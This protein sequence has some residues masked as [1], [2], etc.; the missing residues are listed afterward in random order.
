[1][2]GWWA[3]KIRRTAGY[4]RANAGPHE[5]REL[6]GWLTPAQLELFDRM[7]RADKRHGLDVVAAVR[8]HG[9]DDRDLLVAGLL[10][11][12]GKGRSV[13]LA[14]RIAWSLGQKYG[15]WVWR[16]TGRLPTF[17]SGLDRL[18]RHAAISADLAEKAGCS[19]RTVELIRR[20]E[21]PV[22][23]AGRLLQAA[24]DAN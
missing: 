3:R 5:R 9:V 21:E 1:M 22:D 11:D 4:W 20:Q 6:E 19:P 16:L 10:H 14:H 24:D 12:A 13:G 17:G 18:R 7:H 2:A 15:A 8:G 23:E